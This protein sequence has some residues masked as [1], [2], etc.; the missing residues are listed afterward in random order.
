[1]KKALPLVLG[2]LMF[3]VGLVWTLQGLGYVSGSPMTGV[4]FWAIVGPLLAGLGLALMIVGY[5][6]PR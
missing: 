2:G 5:R 3:V 6:G 1:M 4:A